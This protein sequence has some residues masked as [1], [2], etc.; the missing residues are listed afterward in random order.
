MNFH[1]IT[2][3]PEIF[4][5]Y[6]SESIIKRALELKK[7][8]ISIYDLRTW[9]DD[10]HKTV[11]DRP[12]GGGPGMLLKAGPII[13]ALNQ[14]AKNKKNKK[15]VLFDAA[16]KLWNQAMA[17]NYAKSRD[18]IMICGRYEGIDD[19]I[20]YL[21]DEKIS[22]GRYVLTGG[23][24]PAMVLVDSLVRLI[25][26]VLGNAE[27]AQKESFQG[28]S[29]AGEYPQ[30]TRPRSLLVKG[31]KRSVP[32]SLLNGNHQEIEKWQKQHLKNIAKK[33]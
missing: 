1:I 5:S 6:F 24:I 25:P 4:Q 8:K 21:I 2:I 13:K 18:I 33:C 22:I 9:T 29:D 7:I 11:D 32:K 12:Y 23:E 10:K 3:F 14:V 17:E 15:I 31:R 16:G 27:S 20:K 26:G 28:G 19:R 30:Y